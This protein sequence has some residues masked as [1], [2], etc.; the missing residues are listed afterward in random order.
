MR[1]RFSTALRVGALNPCTANHIKLSVLGRNHHI[2]P[3]FWGFSGGSVVKNPSAKQET[4]VQS[5]IQKD[6]KCSRAT[7]S[8]C[9]S[10]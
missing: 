9:Y 2:N 1:R 3:T 5:L 6:P 10:C 8:T 4:W 7:E